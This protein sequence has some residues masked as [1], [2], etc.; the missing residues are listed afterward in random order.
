MFDP[1]AFDNI[2]VVLEG[3]IYDLDLAGDIIITNRNDLINIGKMDRTYNI[4][5][6]LPSPNVI[7]G[8]IQAQ[9]EINSTLDEIYNE[10]H[11]KKE[12]FG[13]TLTVTFQVKRYL[14]DL[15]EKRLMK[16][17]HQQ[18]RDNPIIKITTVKQNQELMYLSEFQL[19]RYMGEH[20]VD[21][22]KT[23]IGQSVQML[24]LLNEVLS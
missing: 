18:Y 15:A 11:R 6:Q 4:T 12:W 22:L 13:C 1:T 19:K 2:K 9:V 23:F 24:H 14:D 21:D 8:D 16:L 3:S 17:F 20:Q 5:Y 10:W 7:T